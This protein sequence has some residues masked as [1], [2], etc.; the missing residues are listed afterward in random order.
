MSL[1]IRT[2][3]ALRLPMFCALLWLLS[4]GSAQASINCTASMTAVAFGAVDLVAGT[5]TPAN[6]TL[7]YTCTKSGNNNTTEYARVCSTSATATR[8]SRTSIRAS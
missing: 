3:R 4:A 6:A 8:A 2:L 1:L 5:A 7:S